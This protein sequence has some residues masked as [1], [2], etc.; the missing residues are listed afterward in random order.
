MTNED[1][2]L[3]RNEWASVYAELERA[4]LEDE[5]D[6]QETLDKLL[7][8]YI[9]EKSRSWLDRVLTFIGVSPSVGVSIGTNI[10][11]S[12]QPQK[13]WKMIIENDEGVRMGLDPDTNK[14]VQIN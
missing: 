9:E 6:P 2:L 12:K 8:P 10:A 11:R 14:W 4:V 7:K 3:N 13:Q 5:A 1:I